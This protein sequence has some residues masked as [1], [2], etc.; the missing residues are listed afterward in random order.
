MPAKSTS[1]SEL[2]LRAIAAIVL[3]VPAA[4]VAPACS[5]EASGSLTGSTDTTS[6]ADSSGLGSDIAASTDVAGT[7]DSTEATDTAQGTDTAT[8]QDVAAGKPLC[9]ATPN[10]GPCCMN[11]GEWCLAQFPA[12]EDYE[13]R[14]QCQ[15][16]PNYDASTGCSPWGPPAPPVFAPAAWGLA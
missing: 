6:P 2:A 9:V 4:V 13:T 14:A 5:S 16:G 7:S 15:Y 1:P 10:D 12:D 3:T 11:L 8:G